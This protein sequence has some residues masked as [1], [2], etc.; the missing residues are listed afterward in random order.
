M[1]AGG[2]GGTLRVGGHGATLRAGGH[3]GTLRADGRGGAQRSDVVEIAKGPAKRAL[4]RSFVWSDVVPWSRLPGSFVPPSSDRPLTLAPELL[5]R[6]HE[7][8]GNLAG[9]ASVLD[10]AA[11]QRS[12]NVDS[13]F[14]A[15][16]MLAVFDRDRDGLVSRVEFVQGV[17]RLLFGTERDKLRFVFRLHDINGDG[18]IDHEE[19]DRMLELALTEDGVMARQEV[20]QRLSDLLFEAADTNRD[21]RLSFSEFE[22]LANNHPQATALIFRSESS[23][24]AP[25]GELSEDRSRRAGFARRLLRFLDNRSALVIVVLLWV[26]ANA[27]LFTHAVLKYDALGKNELVQIARGCGACINLNGALIVLTMARRTL[28]FARR[29]PLLRLLPL[30]DSVAIHGWLGSWLLIFS[31]V[32]TAA[33]GAN[34]AMSEPGLWA[35]LAESSAGWSGVALLGVFGVIW[36]FSRP[37]IRGSR[38][39]ELFYW[40]HLL[41]LVW[42]ALALLHGP[43]FWM[44]A[45]IPLAIFAVDR[46]LRLFRSVS[47]TEVF[48]CEPLASG[49]TRLTIEKPDEFRHR[50]GDYVYLKL[51]A[52]ARYEWHPFTISSAPERPELTLHVRSLGNFTSALHE[53]ARN[54]S[55]LESPPILRAHLD[56]PFGTAS[57]RIF[58][59]RRAVLIGAG[60]GVTPFASV[61]ESIVLRGQAG[62]GELEKV[63]FYWLNRDAVSFEWFAKLLASLEREAPEGLVDIRIFMTGGRGGNISSTLLNLAREVAHELGDPDVITG[64]ASMTTMGPPDWRTELFAIARDYPDAEV[65]FCG[66]SGLARTIRGVCS[67]LGL[68]FQQ[69]HF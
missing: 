65:F 34:W 2:Y 42:F 12:L 62:E 23:W 51:P 41:Y 39:F 61:L 31:L 68:G 11:L 4:A 69:E 44:W 25:K 35:S 6:I 21:G 64:L 38:H 54:R 14:L 55:H 8:F 46:L 52:L 28:T 15:E 66:P 7:C 30:D 67:E 47:K 27:A 57:H 60:I 50:A 36:L 9:P 58:E 18:Y 48:A 32:H 17:P 53:L 1:R 56:G 37:R 45:G 40:T 26:L 43:V 20:S 22:A 59:S 16:R 13:D 24:I 33:H 3:G 19:L 10:A 63:F 5:A 29:A 49:V